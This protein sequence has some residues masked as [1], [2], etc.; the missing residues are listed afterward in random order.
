MPDTVVRTL[1]TYKNLS[2]RFS[3]KTDDYNNQYYKIYNVRLS[4]MNVYLL[5]AIKRKW[6]D[7]FPVCKLYKLAEENEDICVVIGTLFKDQKLKPSVLKQLAESAQLMPQP[8][9]NHFTDDSDVFYIEDELQRFQL[10]GLA[11]GK[12]L[13]TGI[14]CA[15]LGRDKGNGKFSVIDYTYADYRPQIERPILQNDMYVVLVSGLDLFHLEKSSLSVR[16][17][18]NWLSGYL[19]DINGINTEDIVRL[20]IAGNSVKTSSENEQ[21]NF[22]MNVNINLSNDSI[23]A[24]RTL[25]SFLFELCQVINVDLMPGCKDPSNFVLPQKCFHHCLL[26]KSILYK[27]LNRVTNP[28]ECEINGVRMLGTSGE[29][30]SDILKYS[31]ITEPIEVLENCLKWNHLA[32]TAPDTLSCYPYYDSDPFI[33]DD[34]PHILFCGNQEKFHTKIVQGIL[35]QVYYHCKSNFDLFLGAG[36]QNVRLICVPEFSTSFTACILNLKNFDCVPIVFNAD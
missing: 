10:E 4:Q 17:F 27:T 21:V 33:L 22:T 36:G 9:L 14:T 1:A 31:D 25:D 18:S 11:N 28:Y 24:V 35:I 34:C 2:S 16:L 32:P 6:G 12:Q 30:I 15:L 5:E 19:G 23:E 26:P 7:R 29:P 13:V 20:I 8:I 3:R